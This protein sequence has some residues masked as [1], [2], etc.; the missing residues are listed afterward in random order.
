M[1]FCCE[2]N[3][4]QHVFLF[5]HNYNF[6]FFLILG[7]SGVG[8]GSI[9]VEL[10][11]KWGNNPHFVFPITATTRLPREG[12]EDGK[13]YF[14]ITKEAFEEGIKNNDFLEY[15]I[16]HK[17]QY[18]GLPKKQVIDA[19]NEGKT[20]IR[21]LD[22]QGLWNL[23]ILFKAE[24]LF[25]IFILPPDIE[26]LEMRIRG[27]SVLLEEEIARRI[28]TAR[29]EISHSSECDAQII[30]YQGKLLEA[31]EKVEMFIMKNSFIF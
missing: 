8:K 2:Q 21:E 16:V 7:P 17:T 30:S 13:D 28:E 15:A 19:M 6:M 9:I 26:T 1:G 24:Q 27:R 29:N 12:E 22:I 3:Q 4:N 5:L 10:K 25:S 11:K 31:V 18:Y 20:V 23:K 14:F